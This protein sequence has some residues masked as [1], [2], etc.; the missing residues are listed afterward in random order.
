MYKSKYHY[1]CM[2]VFSVIYLLLNIHVIV[3]CVS[4]CGG[5]SV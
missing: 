2:C 3:V 4:F 5:V 1:V